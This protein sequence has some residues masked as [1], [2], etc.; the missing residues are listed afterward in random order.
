MTFQQNRDKLI[1]NNFLKKRVELITKKIKQNRNYLL[2][3]V[4]NNRWEKLLTNI[5]GILKKEIKVETKEVSF[6]EVQKISGDVNVKFP[7][8]QNVEGKVNVDFPEVQKIKGKVKIDF[9]EVQKVKGKVDINFPVV[10]KVEGNVN[11]KFPENQKV[12]ISN[13]EKIKP[14]SLS[15][16]NLPIGRGQDASEKADPTVYVPVRITNGRQFLEEFG[17]SISSA[18]GSTTSFVD[19]EGKHT[20]ARIIGGDQVSRL[21]NVNSELIN[22]STSDNQTS[23]ITQINDLTNTN[24]HTGSKELRTYQENHVCTDNTTTTPLGANATFTGIWQDCLNYQEVNVSIS[25]DKNSAT[26]GL[27]IQWSSDAVNVGD[28]DRFSVYANSGTNYTPNPSFRYVRIIYTNGS[29]AQNTFSLMTILRKNMTGGSFHRIDSTL[30]D[31]SDGRL[32][33]S[34]PKLKTSANTYISQTATMSGNAKVS[35]EELESGVS[36]NNN[37]QL[38][39]T[40]YTSLGEEGINFNQ[41]N[42]SAFGT[43]ETGE[44]TPVIQ[45]DWVY[46]INNQIWLTPVVSGTGATVDTNLSRLRIQSG[47]NASGYAY[48]MSRKPARYR[49]GQGT[50]FRITP[51]FTAGVTNNIQLWGMGSIISNAPYD[52]YF[53][54]YNGTVFGIVHYNRGTPSWVAQVNWNGITLPFSWD[55]TKGTPV[56]IKYP[57]LGYGDAFFYVQ[58]PLSGAWVL[59]HTIRYANTSATT[60]LANPSLRVIGFTANSGNTTNVTMY[61]GSVGVFISGSR[62]FISNPRWCMDSI[63]TAVTTEEN[64]IS[65]RNATTYNGVENRALLRLSYISFGSSA[66]NGISIIRFRTGATL[67]GTPSFSPINGSTSDNGVTIT[68]GN[69]IASY[70]VAGTT[71]ANGTYSSCITL[72]NPNSQVFNL[73]P[74]ELYIA[75]GETITISSYSSI[76]STVGVGINWSEDI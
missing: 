49:A 30:K 68:N 37:S 55:P 47:T 74:F 22:P 20:R 75:P 27:V 72:D 60:E 53:F 10:Q 56:M 7:Q 71:V 44:L 73:E 13:F 62:L 19:E 25:T 50:M 4:N 40:N 51:V 43:L 31:D 70:D 45:G 48:I 9:P 1:I 24:T 66:A 17:N 32:N 34:V 2:V 5:S 12:E 59:V 6:P 76:S 15:V 23:Q 38:K 35:I 52:G 65:I 18:G 33:I 57:Y 26:D 39:V 61:S 29:V 46:G 42:Q 8:V 3:K 16:D 21:S 63:K 41:A 54:G 58:N 36:V 67:G 28:D 69:S 11:V 64:I 14:T